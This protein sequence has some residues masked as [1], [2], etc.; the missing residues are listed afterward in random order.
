MATKGMAAPE[1]EQTYARARALCAQVGETPSSSRRCGA[2]VG[3]ISTGGRCRRRGSWGTALPAGAAR[4][5]RRCTAWKPMKRSGPP[6]S[7]W[8]NT[9]P[10]G[11]IFE[12]GIALIDPTAQ[13]AL[14][15][16]HGVAPGVRCLVV[17]GQHAVVPGLSGAGR[18]AESGGAGPGPGAGPSLESGVRPALCGLLHHRRREVPAVQA[19]A[20]ALLT[21]AT[22]QGFRSMWGMGHAGGAGR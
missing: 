22:A 18:A 12:Q 3:S 13:R 8:A 11:R 19:Q 17:C 2:Y 15:L 6:C 9:P 14:A 10:P 7:I 1:V 20:E 4:G 21:L 16:R 5:R